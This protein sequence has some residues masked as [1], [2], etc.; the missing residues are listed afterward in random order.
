MPQ[1][2]EYSNDFLFQQ[3][4]APPHFHN[5]VREYLNIELPRRW[6]GR[7]GERDECFI[8]PPRLPDLTPSDFFLWGY[9]SIKDHVY[10]PPL[11]RDVQEL[12]Q[13]I[14]E[15]TMVTEDMLGRVWQ[16]SHVV[17]TTNLCD[18]M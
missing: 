12:K 7:A 14:H 1:I 8:C 18:A 16:E 3:G 2:Q 6:I 13:R 17:P 9:I 15:A 11:P 10:V 4:G 5:D